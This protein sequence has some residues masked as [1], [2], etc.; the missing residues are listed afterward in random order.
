MLFCF[1]LVK[2]SVLTLVGEIW[3]CK[4]SP[5]SSSSCSSSSSLLLRQALGTCGRLPKQSS[6]CGHTLI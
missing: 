2:R 6:V 4:N 1:H 5:S 3:R